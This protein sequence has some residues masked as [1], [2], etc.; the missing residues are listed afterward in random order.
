MLAFRFRSLLLL[1]A[2]LLPLTPWT[3][4]SWTF[5]CTP[6]SRLRLRESFHDR[7]GLGG[8]GMW[9]M[10]SAVLDVLSTRGFFDH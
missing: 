5:L 2:T 9:W 1:G 10:R 3:G 8:R 6:S 7:V 4:A